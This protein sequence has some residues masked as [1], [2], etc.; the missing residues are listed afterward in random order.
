RP[1]TPAGS[2]AAR[3]LP[4]AT[5]CRPIVYRYPDSRWSAFRACWQTLLAAPPVHPPRIYQQAL[6]LGVSAIAHEDCRELS[7]V[8][9]MVVTVSVVFFAAGAQLFAAGARGG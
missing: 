1:R 6:R 2:N 8:V 3:F 9:L 5:A 4:D 7:N